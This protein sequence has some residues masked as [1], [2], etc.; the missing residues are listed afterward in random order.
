[1]LQQSRSS[2]SQ[3]AVQTIN[4]CFDRAPMDDPY[5]KTK[6]YFHLVTLL[7]PR[8]RLRYKRQTVDSF[9]KL[10]QE[11][12]RDPSFVSAIAEMQPQYAQVVVDVDHTEPGDV[13]RS[14]YTEAEVRSV[15]AA[16]QKALK[17]IIL[18]IRPTHLTAMV[19]TKQPYIKT[20]SNGTSKISNGYHIQFPRIFISLEARTAIREIAAKYVSVELDAVE[21]KPWLLYGS[22]KNLVS[23]TYK[24]DYCIDHD[25]T[26]VSV[27]NFLASHKSH[28]FLE[29]SPFIPTIQELPQ[30]L[31]LSP[32][33]ASVSRKDNYV[34]YDYCITNDDKPVTAPKKEYVPLPTA[35]EI[36]HCKELVAG[37]N[38]TYAESYQTWNAVGMAILTTL[39]DNDQALDLWLDFSKKCPE[40]YNEEECRQR[41]GKME[42]GM[43]TKGTLVHYYNESKLLNT[44]TRTSRNRVTAKVIKIKSRPKTF[45]MRP[46]MFKMRKA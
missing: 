5:S 33:L 14:L 29:E 31:A 22:R 30:V 44:K 11:Q 4:Q 32:V 19:L 34:Y 6:E 1:M 27:E 17:Q 15:V 21:N 9:W 8:L 36:A 12:I 23:G 46:K 28:T 3:S 37:I 35:D 18:K 16:Y 45:K 26:R 43:Y 10:Y 20:T 42:G 25:G 7:E 40:K 13:P 2:M 41:W 24:A 39:G 38:S